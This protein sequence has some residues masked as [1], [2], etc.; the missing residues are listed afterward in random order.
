[1]KNPRAAIRVQGSIPGLLIGGFLGGACGI[2]IAARAPAQGGPTTLGHPGAAMI[3]VVTLPLGAILGAPSGLVAGYKLV[4]HYS[5][6]LDARLLGTLLVMLVIA[7]PTCSELALTSC[8][9][10]QVI[11]RKEH[12]NG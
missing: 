12:C 10:P 9:A 6:R 8:S 3:I 2:A 4:G 7:L 1:M 11:V 5:D